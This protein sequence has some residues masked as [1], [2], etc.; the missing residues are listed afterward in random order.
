[1]HIVLQ[2]GFTERKAKASHRG[3]YRQGI[4]EIINLQP[5]SGGRHAKP[6]QVKQIG[7]LVKAYNL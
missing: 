5:T 1:L 2:L 3:F 6:Y 7:A 4:P